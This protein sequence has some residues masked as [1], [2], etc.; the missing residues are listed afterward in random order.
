MRTLPAQAMLLVQDVA[1]VTRHATHAR[2]EVPE[3]SYP[4]HPEVRERPAAHGPNARCWLRAYF[5]LEGFAGLNMH[6]NYSMGLGP[7][8]AANMLH[9]GFN[10]YSDVA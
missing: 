4:A 3:L 10:A 2:P 6:A 8:A 9:A 7:A 1:A 5:D